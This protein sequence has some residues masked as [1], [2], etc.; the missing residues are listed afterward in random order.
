[1]RAEMGQHEGWEI[2]ASARP[3]TELISKRSR[4]NLRLRACRVITFRAC[5]YLDGNPGVNDA[6]PQLCL[7]SADQAVLCAMNGSDETR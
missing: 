1:M 5:W 6:T 7:L 2:E 4:P 3:G